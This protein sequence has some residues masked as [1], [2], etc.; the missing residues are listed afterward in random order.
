MRGVAILCAAQRMILSLGS[1]DAPRPWEGP[2]G[3]TVSAG[4]AK[5][6][7]VIQWLVTLEEI[8]RAALWMTRGRWCH[9]SCGCLLTVSMFYVDPA[10]IDTR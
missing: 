5:H 2:G 6:R 4:G 10:T 1:R 3:W 8:L 9:T 7:F